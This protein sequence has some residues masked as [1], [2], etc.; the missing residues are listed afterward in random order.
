M[1]N[2]LLVFFEALYGTREGENDMKRENG[3]Q[4][5]KCA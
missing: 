2:V 5:Y 3:L 1:I 4:M